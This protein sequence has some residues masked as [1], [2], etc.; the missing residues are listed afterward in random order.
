MTVLAILPI[1][2]QPQRGEERVRGPSSQKNKCVC[3]NIRWRERSE[4]KEVKQGVVL[5]K[6]KQ[7]SWDRWKGDD[8]DDEKDTDGRHLCSFC[9]LCSG[10]FIGLGTGKAN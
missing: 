9:E 7:S 3:I 2:T 6:F 10:F 1:T 8:D 5:W 4:R